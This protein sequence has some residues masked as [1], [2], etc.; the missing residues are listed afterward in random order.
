MN[1]QLLC[2]SLWLVSSSDSGSHWFKSNSYI[3]LIIEPRPID[4]RKYLRFWFSVKKATLQSQMSVRPCVCP[5]AKPFISLKSSSFIIHLSSFI[6]LH[7]CFIILHS[8]FLHF[9]T[10][11]LFSLFWQL[12]DIFGHVRKQ[13]EKLKS[14]KMKEGWM[15]NDKAWMKNERWMMKDDDFKLLKGFALGWTNEWTDRHLR[16]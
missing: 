16:L 4:W 11:K 8:S 2:K 10:F 1:V 9:A 14:R 7:S 12:T 5:K 3:R 6:I 15:K 13:A